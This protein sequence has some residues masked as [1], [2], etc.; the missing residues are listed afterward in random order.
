[1][2]PLIFVTYHSSAV[3]LFLTFK[4]NI[5]I[6]PFKELNYGKQTVGNVYTSQTAV[7]DMDETFEEMIN[8]A[9]DDDIK[10][11]KLIGILADESCDIAVFKKLDIYVRLVRYGKPVTH[12]VGN[13]DV[14]DGK[15]ET[16]TN[17]LLQFLDYKNIDPATQLIGM[18]SDGAAVMIGAHNGVGV[19]LCRVAPYLVHT[20]CVAHRLALCSAQSAKAVEK[21]QE[22]QK[23]LK[24]VYKFFATSA[25]RYNKLREMQLVLE[26]NSVPTTLKDTTPTRWLS[27][28]SAVQAIF[29][30]WPSLVDAL[31]HIASE[32]NNDS[33]QKAKSYLGR[34]EK[35]SFVAITCVL[36]DILPVITKL[37]ASFQVE[38]IDLSVVPHMV[39]STIQTLNAMLQNPMALPHLQ[40]LT[41]DLEASGGVYKQ[42]RLTFYSTANKRNFESAATQFLTELVHNLKQRFPDDAMHVL[43]SL[44]QILNPKSLPDNSAAI[45]GHDALDVLIKQFGITRDVDGVPKGP[46]FDAQV[47]KSDFLQFKYL[48]N[49]YKPQ[50]PPE[51][52]ATF[53]TNAIYT[54]QFPS[55]AFLA[56]VA[57]TLP[58]SSAC[59]E[60]GFSCQNRLKTANRNRLSE[61]R[62][63]SLVKIAIEGPPIAEFDFN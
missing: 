17:V 59:C 25:V 2:L 42:H 44:D 58:I 51:F 14:P 19:H 12:F 62:L 53:L 33:A 56:N 39:K 26:E 55:F 5:F 27:L 22:Y 41:Q 46:L 15:A 37:S 43:K 60:R 32:N 10:N 40:I 50:G 20:H 11:S 23:T 38:N 8:S 63:A 48:L 34:I 49:S 28:H 24:D 57:L 4:N 16:I 35:Y 6:F 13:V 45:P 31:G 29:K 18:G 61:G 1:M 30:C 3:D 47:A 36:L 7:K 54:T 52:C 9:I 21:F